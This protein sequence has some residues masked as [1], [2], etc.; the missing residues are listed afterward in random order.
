[1]SRKEV[2]QVISDIGQELFYVQVENHSDYL[3]S[4]QHLPNLKRHRWAMQD[5]TMNT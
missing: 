5:Q 1:M 2:I 4:G 3:I